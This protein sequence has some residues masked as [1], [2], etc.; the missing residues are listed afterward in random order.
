MTRSALG[1]GC[2]ALLL[3]A[4]GPVGVGFAACTNPGAVATTRAQADQKCHCASA[5][6]HGQYVKCVAEVANDAVTA[7][8]LPTTC[9]G[10]VKK[11]AAK[12]TCGKPGFVSC[13]VTKNGVTKCKI[14]KDSATCA[15]KGGSV[16]NCP[17]C[18]DA[19]TPGGCPTNGT[20][21][22]ATATTTTTTS[23]TVCSQMG[24]VLKGSL[25]ATAGRFNYNLTIGLPG[26]NSACNTNFPGTHACTYSELQAAQAAGDLAGLK[27]TACN[28]VTSFWAIDSSQ[29]PLQQC[30]DDVVSFLNWEYA[31]AHTASR[32]Q[33]VALNN[34]A[35]TLG[36]LQSGVQC[37][38]APA[39]WLGCCQ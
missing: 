27:D 33:K 13:C 18:C 7:G 20:T 28:T 19:C 35:G 6:D 14:S 22:T 10:A 39:N 3:T 11:C 38:F 2:A 26:A 8:T 12:S 31:T 34:P 29:P 1:A 24:V 23:T 16:G 15:A 37:N 25:T 9:K 21:T 30:Q 5:T 36:V 4:F 17:S 32:G